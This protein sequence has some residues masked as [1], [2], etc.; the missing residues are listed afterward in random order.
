MPNSGQ[1]A[2]QVIGGVNQAR[3]KNKLNRD[4][5]VVRATITGPVGSKCILYVGAISPSRYRDG[6]SRGQ[7][8]YAEYP[9]GFLWPAG[10][11]L[12]FVWDLSGPASAYVEYTDGT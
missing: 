2:A 3:I 4:L 7:Q 6:S 9:Q 10:N 1:M 8:D 11:D 5:N 12:I